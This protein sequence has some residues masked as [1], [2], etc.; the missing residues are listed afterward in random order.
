MKV[1]VLVATM[2]ENEE[3]LISKMNLKT[4]A[5]ICKQC[6]SYGYK[7]IIDD[8]KEVRIYSFNE[9]GVGK[10]RNNALLRMEA[11]IALLADDDIRYCEDYEQKILK[12]FEDNVDAD[13]IIFNLKE[14]NGERFEIT[15][16]HQVR[17]YNF[18]RYG[19]ARIAFKT[20]SIRKK[21]IWF[22]LLFGGG[23]I[24]GSGEDTV[25]LSDC[26]KNELKII[27]VPTYIG[28]ILEDRPSTW[29]VGY[30]EKY[31]YDKG[32]LFE[33]ISHKYSIIII[34]QFLLRRYFKHKSDIPFHS[35]LKSSLKG[36]KD[37]SLKN[38]L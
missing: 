14:K 31:Y 16:K 21:N 27:A 36:K 20:D 10:N 19:A 3:K 28:E 32:A 25:F 5:I 8:K 7:K 24:Y 15:Q 9:K 34:I 11:D 12:A 2:S 30:G 38:K 17:W 33:K 1:E 18:M 29:F 13:I 6:D 26:L 37:Y 35:A 22:S 4:N 23:T